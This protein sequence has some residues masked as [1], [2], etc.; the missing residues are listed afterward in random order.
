MKIAAFNINNINRR[1]PTPA[2]ILDWA[3]AYDFAPSADHL[4]QCPQPSLRDGPTMPR[5]RSE[6]FDCPL[7]A[8]EIGFMSRK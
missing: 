5:A 7:I 2:N 6:D 3:S 4:F 1:L 8:V